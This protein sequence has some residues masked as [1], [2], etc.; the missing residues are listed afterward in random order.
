MHK[1]LEK[2]SR[3]A[4]FCLVLMSILF[5][6]LLRA[7]VAICRE[8]QISS[9]NRIFGLY[10]PNSPLRYLLQQMM[11]RNP[12]RFPFRQILIN[13]FIH[14]VGLKKNSTSLQK[15]QLTSFSSQSL[16]TPEASR[17]YKNFMQNIF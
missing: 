16:K 6:S 9:E 12:K 7:N 17:L 14:T 4:K 13:F 11:L 5:G 2:V 1:V 10:N 3:F 8:P 15:F